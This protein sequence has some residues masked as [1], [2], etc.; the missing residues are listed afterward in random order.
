M[1]NLNTHYVDIYAWF[2]D[3]SVD[4]PVEA[5]P[6]LEVYDNFKRNKVRC[7][8]GDNKVCTGELDESD[9]PNVLI[10]KSEDYLASFIVPLDILVAVK[11][12]D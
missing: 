3:Y 10:V 6:A 12:R 1:E 4:Q 5:I 11:V 9:N 2:Q 7:Y 8:Y